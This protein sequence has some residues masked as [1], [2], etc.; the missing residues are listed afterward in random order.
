M[1]SPSPGT[2]DDIGDKHLF[3]GV[4]FLLVGF[5][6]DDA[7][8]YRSEM[9]RRGGADAGPSGN[10]CTHVVVWNLIYDDPTC[11]AARAQGKK[12]VNGLWVEDSL[13]CGV[14]ADADRVMY[15]P[16]RDLKGI[17]GAPSLLI[18][19]TGYQKSY[20]EDMMKMVSLM[21]ARFSKPLIA[22]AVTHLICYKFEGD[23]YE[24]AKKVNIKLVNH[25]WLEDCLKAWKI[26][27]V[28]DYSKSGWERELM[29]AQAIDSEHEAEAS[30]PGSMNYRPSVSGNREVVAGRNLNTPNHIINTEDANNKTHDIRGQSSANSMVAVSAKIDVFAP[31]Q[32]PSVHIMNIEDADSKTHHITGQDSPD[33]GLL[34]SSAKADILA[35][36]QSSGEKKDIVRNTDSPNL[37]EVK[38]K[39]AGART[40][41]LA[42]GVLGPPSTSKMTVFRNHHV[43]TLN[44][45]LGILKVHT[46][47]VSGKYSASHDQ[48]DVAEV[49][50]TS[51]LIGNQSVDEL[52][53]SKDD[54]WQHQEKDGPSGIH[55]AAPGQ[56][57]VDS[58][59]NNHESN[60][61]PGSDSMS[62]NIKNTSNDKKAYRKSFLQEGHSVNHMASPQRAEESTLRGYPNI[63]SLET[64]HQ[65]VVEHADVQ[66]IQGNQNT[67]NED[68]VD[69]T[70][71]EKRK[72]LVSPACLNLQKEDLV[73]ETG[74]LDSPFVS[75]LSGASETANVSS[76]RINLVETNAINL[77]NQHS[78]FSTSKQTR[79]R[80]TSLKH[81]GPIGGIKL[82]DYSSSDKNVKSL[83][84]ARMSFKA[85][86]ESKC[87]MSSSATVQD[88]K[89]SAGF[90]F[91]NKD[92]EST[93]IS[94]NAV[95]QDC[96]NE[97]GNACT[98]DQAHEKS[99]NSSNNSQ[100]V[101]Y[102]GNA[103]NRIAD[104]VKV[105]GN[106]VAVASS[107][108]LKKV[109]SDATVKESTQQFQNTS[110]NVQ[111]ETSYSKKAP[112][113]IRRNAGVKR[114]LSANI[115]SEGSVINSD[116]K[117]VPESS[118]AKVMI[119]HEHAG[120][121]SKNGNSAACAAELKINPPKKAPI[122]R[123][124][125]TVAKR[126]RSACTKIDGTWVGSS[127]QFSKVM[128]QENI[129]IN[130]TKNLDTANANEQ[131]RNSPKKIPNTRVRNR[132][133]KRSLKSDTN[134]SND[135]LMVKAETVAAG[136]LFDDWFPSGNVEDEDWPKK[137]PGHASVN[138][139]ETLSPK[140]VSNAR[141][142]N[143][144]AK[145]KI[146][147]VEDKS[148]GKFGK[149]G[150]AITSETKAFSSKRTE[151]ISCNINKVIADP[152]SEKSNKDVRR[153]VSGLF[154]Q[155]SCTIDKQGPYNSKLRSSKR[156]KALTSAHEK[157]NRLGCSD[158]NS[159]PDRTGSLCSI[160]DAESMKKSTLVLSKHQREKISESGTLITS[161]PA[162][163]ILSGNRQQRRDYRSILRRLKGRV[164]RDSH[165]WSYQATHF[166][167]PDPLRRTEKFFAAAAAGRWILKRE[168]LTSCIEAGKFLDEEPF[169][170]FGTGFNDGQ[171][172]SFDAPRK[173][174]NIRQQMGHGA[175]YRMQIVVYGQLISPTLDTVKR[176]VKAG[177]GVILATLPPYTRFLDSGVDF[178]VVSETIPRADAWVQQFISH[179]IPCVSADYL[180]EYVCKPGQPLDRHVLFKTNHLANKSLEKLM[181]NQQEM[182]M[183]RSKPSE[184]DED[185]PEEDLSCSVCGQKDR[186][187][188]MLICGDE[189]GETGCGIGMHID[190][191]DPPLDAVPDDDWLCPK[192][193]V[194]K[195]KTKRTTTCG[196]K[197]KGRGVSS[198]RRR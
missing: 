44:G 111:A 117:V 15:W 124:T 53:S 134:M 126:T 13:D 66:S 192:C 148:G 153:E 150:S 182:A 127:L 154:C 71:A 19:L 94:G 68:G 191:C 3:D 189:D 74:P 45:T 83:R 165:H 21:G 31:I 142:R 33:S 137:I 114:H 136:S 193:A 130:P 167:A 9:V 138:D 27:P 106:E 14:L 109:V 4:R 88:G 72:S 60:P 152:E 46:D 183:V 98:K 158:L 121:V 78:S 143:A 49:L 42:S 6:S 145:R 186:G 32:S 119:H 160:S 11:V 35:P 185:D 196:T 80:K 38:E 25:R 67:K 128:P 7:S 1:A 89:T 91:Q 118:P 40:Q 37:Q 149:V 132:A 122:C 135:T 151:G 172:I 70:Y 147:T 190:C 48:T 28:S 39:Y 23:K 169:E 5:N 52:D 175:F 57:N 105:N 195:S 93:Q 181:K 79:S 144:A 16:M 176:A 59:L 29:D 26:L 96:L 54:K 112:T 116:K 43:D 146:K 69:G 107:S 177:D 97:I 77:G 86:T 18:C 24:V 103:G 184:D 141:I 113:T 2:D 8:Q 51:P 187:D 73:S 102:Y 178:A 101:P 179:G 162:L 188:V 120:P 171:T 173:W 115:E 20:R 81:G 108:E 62:N 90:Q 61:K 170:W 140:T 63:S 55:I 197:R 100:V 75:R 92:G 104:P 17:P 50:L 174:R 85:T 131:Q 125:D 10:G 12:V 65:K 87:T 84:K 123:V 82:P 34:A 155:D 139:C 129:E 47:H 157:E 180:V 30:D 133:V 22:N 64:A 159:K 58:K 95:N 36:I 166:I 156:N 76:E 163:F 110:R 161:E 194:P 99:V 168:Y 198:S 41:D 164:C 56:L